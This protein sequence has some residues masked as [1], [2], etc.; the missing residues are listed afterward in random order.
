MKPPLFVRPLTDPERESLKA[1][2]RSSEAFTVRRCQILLASARGERA[3]AIARV[4]GCD[5]DTVR[6]TIHAFETRGCA[7]LSPR[8]RRPHH[9]QAAFN[10]AGC[11][12]LRDLVRQDPR[13]SGYATS[14]WTL[15]LLAQE[16]QRRGITAELV[17]GETVRATLARAGIRWQRAKRWIVSSDPD[18]GKK[19]DS[20]TA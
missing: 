18:Y 12:A 2:L 20:A 7:A 16:C 13:V 14:L 4:V 1:G 3:S 11:D 5:D 9:T 19:N 15:P 17:S 10:A 8:S 6:K